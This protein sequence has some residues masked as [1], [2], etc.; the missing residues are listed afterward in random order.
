LVDKLI[1]LLEILWEHQVTKLKAH[2][3]MLSIKLLKVR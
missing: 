3:Q 2:S 1:L